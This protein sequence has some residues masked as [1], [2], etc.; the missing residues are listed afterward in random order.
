METNYLNHMEQLNSYKI[1]KNILYY[2][3]IKQK[4]KLFD[5]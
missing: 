3:K 4:L 2:K 1:L 5:Y